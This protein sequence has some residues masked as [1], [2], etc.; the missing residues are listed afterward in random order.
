MR[1]SKDNLFRVSLWPGAGAELQSVVVE[2]RD[3]EEALVLASTKIGI[4]IP[5][6]ESDDEVESSDMYTYIDRSEHGFENGYLLIVNGSI[7]A[8]NETDANNYTGKVIRAGGKEED[9]PDSEES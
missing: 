5:M 8:M 6:D 9:Y 4:I 1:I 3:E 2:A 7:Y